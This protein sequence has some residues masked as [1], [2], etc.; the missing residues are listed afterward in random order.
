MTR[1]KSAGPGSR[2]GLA[3]FVS[4]GT[5]ILFQVVAFKLLGITMGNSIHSMTAVVTSFMGGLAL[6]S[7]VAGRILGGRDPERTY[8]VLETLAAFCFLGF[9]FALDA[10]E[11]LLR[12]TYHLAGEDVTILTSVRFVIAGLLLLVPTVMMG[13]TL[14]IL[15]Q[16]TNHGDLSR[17]TSRLYALNSAG[18]VAGALAGPFLLLPMMGI[19]GTLQVIALANLLIALMVIRS[20]RGALA[21]NAVA[22]VE[23]PAFRKTKKTA[24][25]PDVI[26]VTVPALP[27]A[28][29]LGLAGFAAMGLEIAWTRALV[30]IVGSSVY[31]FS[32][33]LATFIAGLA[34]G[35]HLCSLL[36][37]RFDRRWML[38]VLLTLAS[39]FSML[40]I[41]LI[42]HLPL[43]QIDLLLNFHSSWW[44][45]ELTQLVLV[46]SVTMVPAMFMGACFPVATGLLAGAAD[47]TAGAVGRLYSANTTGN[48]LGSLLTGVA[49]IPA[50]G[51]ETTLAVLALL[52]LAAA[53][54]AAVWFL[55]R[56]TPRLVPAM[57]LLSIPFLIAALLPRWDTK[58]LNCG[59]YV[60]AGIYRQ[61]A[62]S[63]DVDY[64]QAID[65][66]NRLLYY[67]E[68]ISTTVAV[69]E[70]G[71]GQRGLAIN[72][73]IDASSQQDMKTQRMAGHLP[74]LLHPA[75]KDALVIGLG[76]GVTLASVLSHPVEAVDLVEIS[77][78]V[79]GASRY[80]QAV[81]YDA[82]HDKRLNLIIGDGRNHM[83]MTD[84]KYD[85]I[86]SE[87]T[88]PWIAGVGNLFTR[89]YY[90]LVKNR[91]KPGGVA[92]TWVQAYSQSAEDFKSVVATF[93]S[94]FPGA[95]MWRST[96]KTDYF[97]V[98]G[99]EPVTVDVASLEHRFSRLRVS[100][101]LLEVGIED[102]VD[103]LAHYMATGNELARFAASGEIITDDSL[104]LELFAPRNLYQQ[105]LSAGQ[106][107]E[108]A[109][110]DVTQIVAGLT[111]GSAEH[112]KMETL[113]ESR[114]LSHQ[115]VTL[116]RAG[117]MDDAL[118]I[119]DQAQRLN[120]DRAGLVKLV[121][122]AYG[123]LATVMLENDRVEVAMAWLQKVID[124]S[125]DQPKLQA[126][127]F[128]ELG[129]VYG[130]LKDSGQALEAYRKASEL[131]ETNLSAWKNLGLARVEAGELRE[132]VDAYERA[133]ALNAYDPKTYNNLGILY[134]K[135]EKMDKARAAY[136]S[137]IR[138]DPAFEK[139]K[140]NLRFL[141]QKMIASGELDPEIGAL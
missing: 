123:L 7:W 104:R 65:E 100:T 51:L 78:E 84:R 130:R 107:T 89:E 24:A 47:D 85:V 101:D 92:V 72:G 110:G 23:A 6:G 61:R 108:L 127:M 30:L 66:G 134:E 138:V 73:K 49:L 109:R 10:F 97:L 9:P 1:G 124:L 13:A 98:G 83:A 60:Y 114:R 5:A 3:F 106:I 135:L 37:G 94:V 11:P 121:H 128:N 115:A 129:N 57:A 8:A 90:T 56:P 54:L 93:R 27:L 69:V 41:P 88:N 53:A 39:G 21:A 133:V 113:L 48:I 15:I 132:A 16:S 34:V 58:V 105:D 35:S 95:S 74:M 62:K 64:R 52:Q 126:D 12:W 18:A 140:E 82:P 29:V 76:S 68:G 80:F 22:P 26:Q 36:A 119:L 131:D 63:S 67:D 2:I 99:L 33:I 117:K 40:S 112:R 50:L 70:G 118:A 139:P 141:E 102:S 28:L 44:L 45:L 87:P 96:M 19:Q 25:A 120:L 125:G 42:G 91:L 86:A 59:P 75:P 38:P 55:P 4:G 81:N 20:R 46:G 71:D 137:A 122:S 14:P 116:I 43:I 103:F 111:R 79:V 17:A 32:L 31:A 136:A 77:P